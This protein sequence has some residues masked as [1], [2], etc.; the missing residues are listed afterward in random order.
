MNAKTELDGTPERDLPAG[1]A[2]RLARRRRTTRVILPI[3]DPY[4]VHHGA[5]GSFATVYLDPAHVD[6]AIAH[7]CARCRG[8][9]LV[10]T[11]EAAALRFELPPDR[12]GDLVVVAERRP[13][14]GTIAAR[15]D[16]SRPRRAAALARRRL[17]AAR[18]ADR[19]PPRHGP[20]PDRR[21]RN[22]DAF[23]LALNHA[24]MNA[25]AGVIADAAEAT[26]CASPASRSRSDRRDR[27]PQPV[28]RRAGR[29]RA[30][31]DGRR[32]APRVRASRARTEPKLTRYERYRILQ[33]AGDADRASARDA[34][35][36]D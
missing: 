1:P 8:I 21:W 13:C 18:A 32:R 26:H 6:S 33:R 11:R 15:H 2:R 35:A 29:H 36:R 3:T 23:D 9:E 7:A 14:I 20:R 16:L 4:V 30:E 22:F 28:H 25:I 27:G 12:I 24:A 17:R 5:L 19:Q 34:I 10:L 31:G